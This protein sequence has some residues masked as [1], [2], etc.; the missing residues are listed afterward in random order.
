[1]SDTQY[2][3]FRNEKF[4]NLVATFQGV[5]VNWILPI[6][7]TIINNLS[8]LSPLLTETLS[9]FF[10]AFGG[11]LDQGISYATQ[12]KKFEKSP[13]HYFERYSAPTHPT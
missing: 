5:E 8:A 3:T 1:M 7:S 2:F 4:Q 12:M 6:A 13:R 11:L 9:N 10:P